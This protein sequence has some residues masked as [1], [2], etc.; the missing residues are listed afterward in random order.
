[1]LQ[2][3]RDRLIGWVLWVMIG[4]ICVPFAFW[5]IQ[6]IGSGGGD[7]VLAKVG[8]WFGGLVGGERITE[9]QLRVQYERRYQQLQMMMGDSFRAD[10]IDPKTFREVVLRD[11]IQEIT[12]RQFSDKAG[13]AAPDSVLV[14]AIRGIPAFQGKDG[15]FSLDAY[16][17]ALA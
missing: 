8:G 14:E 15:Q 5:G 17:E 4:I 11:M 1:M 13:Y 9:S 12:L 7:P 3:I 2:A 6:S 16:H 10:Q